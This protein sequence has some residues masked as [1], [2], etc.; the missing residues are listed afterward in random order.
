[1]IGPRSPNILGLQ[2]SENAGFRL[3]SLKVFFLVFFWMHTSFAL[4]AHWRYFQRCVQHGPQRPNFG[5]ILDPN[6]IQNSELWSLFQNLFTG[7]TSVLLHM[8]IGCTFR[9]VQNMTHRCHFLKNFT[10]VVHQVFASVYISIWS[11]FKCSRGPI[12]V[13]IWA[14]K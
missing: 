11:I 7:F 5:A 9:C 1:M 2:M 10:L 13:L 8:L 12:S 4:S 3:F 14:P 6:I